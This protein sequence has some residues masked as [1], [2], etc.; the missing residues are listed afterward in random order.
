MNL[1]DVCD[2]PAIKYSYFAT[3]WQAVIWRNWGHVEISNIAKALGTT[4]NQVRKEAENLGLNKDENVNPMWKTRGYINTIRVNWH[5]CTFEQIMILL[6][7]TEEK[8]SMILKEDDFFWHKMGLFKPMLEAPV[9]KP[10]NEQ[11]IYETEKLVTYLDKQLD[12]K[13]RT[14]DKAFEFIENYFSPLSCEESKETANCVVTPDGLRLIYSYFANYGDPLIDETLD[15]FPEQ[16]LNKYAKIGINGIWMQAVLYQ[17]SEF[18]FAPEISIGYKKRL[19]NLRKLI[20]RAFKYGIRVYLYI[21]EP[22]SMD[23]I[24]FSKYPELRGTREDN[25]YSMCTSHPDVQNY[26]QSATR[27]L[28]EN[29]EGLAGVFTISM[30][31]NLTNCYSRPT[32]EMC[33]RC[34]ERRPWEIVAEVNNLIAKGAKEGNSDAQVIVWSWAWKDDW[35]S[36]IPPLLTEGQIVMCTSEEGVPT[37]IENTKGSVIDYSMSICGPGEKAKD[38]WRAA[39][40]NHLE[41]CAKMQ[42]NNTWE[43]AAIPWIPVFDKVAEHVNN[44]KKE[45]IKHQFLSWTLG[46]CPSPNLELVAWLTDNCGDVKSFLLNQLGEELNE[47]AY[48]A[49]QKFSEAF[50]NFPFHV[51]TLYVGPQNYGPMAPFFLEPTEYQAT[52][53][54]FPYDDLKSWRS[55]YSEEIFEKQFLEIK[56][57]WSEGVRIMAPYKGRNDK[58]DEMLRM[59]SA[60]LCHFKSTHNH[61]Q[62]VSS[63]NRFQKDPKPEYKHLML[64]AIDKERNVVHEIMKLR[65]ED[66]RIG[67]EASNHYFYSLQDLMEKLINLWWC[68][69][70]LNN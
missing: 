24:F 66:S 45:D 2:K 33:S 26:I 3:S 8:L 52:M 13:Y 50:S 51:S 1:P 60:A 12:V 67:Y 35:A 58:F 54:G 18:P 30:S 62:F 46:G 38:I 29:A 14:N 31:E 21:N 32:D 61:I 68:E 42:V 70:K 15:P 23:S 5:L 41:T 7:I 36:K 34:K 49:Q 19:Q 59:A 10:L 65:R 55:I 44:L 40:R 48:L 11:E 56:S 27:S 16:L 17:L 63:R 9:Y 20:K 69:E 4:E 43:L 53:L 47:I 22:R 6:D 57:V 39:N 37:N 25:Y 28:F 64:N